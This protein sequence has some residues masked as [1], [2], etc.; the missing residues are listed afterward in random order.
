MEASNMHAADK[1]NQTCVVHELGRVATLTA[2]RFEFATPRA[3][4]LESSSLD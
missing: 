1:R 2:A 4:R 3:L